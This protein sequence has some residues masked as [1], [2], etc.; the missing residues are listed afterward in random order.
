MFETL[1]YKTK[2]FFFVVIKISIVVVAFY[3]IYNKLSANDNLDFRVFIDFLS[4]NDVFSLKNGVFLV[5]LS[6]FNWFFEIL[7]WQKLVSFVKK[8]NFKTALQQSLGALTASLFTPNRIGDYGAKAMCFTS[9]YRKRI[10]FLN[11]LGNIMQM[12]I[13]VIFGVIGLSLFIKKYNVN[14]DNY[15]TIKILVLIVLIFSFAFFAMKQN[16]FK[17]K[18]FSIEKI[19]SF[20]KNIPLKIHAYSFILSVTRYVIFS[21]QFY[22]LLLIFGADLSYINAMLVITSMYLLASVIPSVFIFDVIIKGSVAVYL[23]SIV[24]VNE[25]TILC[26]VTLMWLLNFVFPSLI[27]S[28][29]VL[30]FNLPKDNS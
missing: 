24:G 16:R 23:F 19:I 25:I 6:V 28:F 22:Y 5:F 12:C 4:K 2:Q 1:P 17:I 8:I 14:I 21:F 30:N 3:F 9:S 15:N 13:T 10:M 29:Y 18:G 7:K 20:I 26:I 11:L 27:G